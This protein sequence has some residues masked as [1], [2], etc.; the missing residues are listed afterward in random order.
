MFFSIC[1]D[2]ITYETLEWFT[3]TFI[4]T[5]TPSLIFKLITFGTNHFYSIEKYINNIISKFGI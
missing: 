5:P 1:Y 3:L 2:F 4:T